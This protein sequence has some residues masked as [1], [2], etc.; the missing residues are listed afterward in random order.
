MPAP[1]SCC[2]LV[3]NVRATFRGRPGPAGQPDVWRDAAT[4]STWSAFVLGTQR[5]G[6]LTAAAAAQAAALRLARAQLEE[7]LRRIEAL[8]PAG[9]GAG[10]RISPPPEPT[11]PASVA[12]EHRRLH[13]RL[14]RLH[15]LTGAGRLH[16]Q[17]LRD[18]GIDPLIGESGRAGPKR[19]NAPDNP[20][21][22]QARL[23]LGIGGAPRRHS[24]INSAWCSASRHPYPLR[25]L[26]PAYRLSHYRL[27]MGKSALKAEGA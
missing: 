3:P 13:F 23:R 24:P 7:G 5:T 12:V 17:H 18:L 4:G 14:N 27:Q 6:F 22:W 19:L 26:G 25:F 1:A 8:A 21:L 9:H 2:V 10:A 15:P 11:R 16:R 20:R